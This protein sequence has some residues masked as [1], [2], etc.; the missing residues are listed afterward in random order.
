[1]ESEEGSRETSLP[2]MHLCKILSDVTD[3]V[4][5]LTPDTYSIIFADLAAVAAYELISCSEDIKA[6]NLPGIQQVKADCEALQATL[7]QLAVTEESRGMVRSEMA[8]ASDYFGFM[9][10]PGEIAIACARKDPSLYSKE[11]YLRLLRITVPGR[12]VQ[13]MDI[14]AMQEI[15]G[16]PNE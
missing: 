7:L 10:Q 6:I 9:A 3:S 8:R 4:S 14:A 2:V 11:E 13:E 1:M 16:G 15:V 5:F 12:F